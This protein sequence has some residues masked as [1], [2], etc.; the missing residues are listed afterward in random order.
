[1]RYSSKWPTYAQQWDE[2]KINSS[3]LGEM[4]RLAQF[5]LDHK[6]QYV[7][8]ES[9]TGVPWWL[10]AVLHRR[11]SDADFSTYLGNGDPLNRPT[12]NVPA[13]RGPFSSFLAGAIDA[14]KQDGLSSVIDWRLEKALYYCE[15]FNGAGYDNRGLPSP[16]IWGGTNQQHA[17]KYVSDG[18]WSSTTM[19][20]QPGCAP[21]LAMIANLDKTV[22][23]VRESSDTTAQ[24]TEPAKPVLQPVA[25]TPSGDLATRIVSA[26]KAKGYDITIGSYVL[27]IVYVEGMNRDGTRNDNRPNV[28]NDTRML[29]RCEEN[30]PPVIIGNWEATTTPGRF[31]T[32]HRLNPGGAFQIAL[33]QQT[34]WQIGTYH[35]APALR[36]AGPLKHYRDDND[37]YQRNGP[38]Y[39]S[40]D[41]GVHHHAGYNYKHDDIGRSSAGCLVGRM[42]DGHAEFMEW[43]SKDPRYVKDHRFLFTATILAQEDVLG[44]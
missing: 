19:D 30:K 20:S 42:V 21:I 16:Y 26:M 29:I 38:L 37:D 36:Q 28:F 9:A 34:A 6:P 41:T 44:V 17:G 12:R 33:G 14:L 10:I 40:D 39:T 15:L 24:P 13:G 43:L 35:D 3:R 8:V 27:N 5:A 1:M 31:W 7:A 18:V 32:E 11:E 22:N 25:P 23:F 2:M 4:T